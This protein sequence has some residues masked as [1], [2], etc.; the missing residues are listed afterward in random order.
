MN[1]IQCLH[2]CSCSWCRVG[3]AGIVVGVVGVVVGIARGC[4]VAG[5]G[6]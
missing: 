1:I 6:R 2:P 3:F 5:T 4:G